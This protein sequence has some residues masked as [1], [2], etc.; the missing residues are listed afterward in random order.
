MW[1]SGNTTPQATQNDINGLKRNPLWTVLNRRLVPTGPGTPPV[2]K[3]TSTER[4]WFYHPP[5]PGCTKPTSVTAPSCDEFPYFST[6]QGQFGP[7]KTQTPHTEFV[8]LDENTL[9]GSL[10]R[11]FYSTDGPGIHPWFGCDISGQPRT[12]LTANPA[13]RYM[14][15]PSRNVPT[16]AVCNKPRSTP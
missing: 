12:D 8:E 14:A 15:L 7:L 16:F 2:W 6:L 1:I 11:K 3:F 4:E 9:Q 5:T 13:S 10:L